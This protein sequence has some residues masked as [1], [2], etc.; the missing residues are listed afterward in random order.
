MMRRILW[1]GLIVAVVAAA[2]A[3]YFT[4]TLWLDKVS[5]LWAK[6]EP[7]KK[8]DHE[9]GG[10]AT[11][12]VLSD[13]AQ[14]NLNLKVE[15]IELQDYWRKIQL[16]GVI[17]D[18]P[19]HDLLVTSTSVGIITRVH[20]LPGRHRQ[21]WRSALHAASCQRSHSNASTT[22]HRNHEEACHHA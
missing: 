18:Q 16:P 3:G 13:Q 5:F 17:V 19:G 6:K 15:P 10:E 1:I 7:E 20:V 8:D 21:A 11:S 4:R 14:K 2:G 22:I 12:L 9:D